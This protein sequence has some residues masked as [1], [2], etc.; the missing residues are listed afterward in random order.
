MMIVECSDN[1]CSDNG[2]DSDWDD[3]GVS[4]NRSVLLGVLAYYVVLGGF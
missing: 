2:P 4:S 1:E 3:S